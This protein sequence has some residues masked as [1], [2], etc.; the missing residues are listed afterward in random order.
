ML[1]TRPG[2][3]Y[4]VLMMEKRLEVGKPLI[5][6]SATEALIYESIF[7]S[8]LSCD[9]YISIRVVR[10]LRVD[11]WRRDVSLDIETI[12]TWLRPCRL[13]GLLIRGNVINFHWLLWEWYIYHNWALLMG[14]WYYGDIGY[15]IGDIM[16]LVVFAFFCMDIQHHRYC[17]I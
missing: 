11:V 5:W 17:K 7:T 2:M 9:K 12:P 10:R 13:H 4:N 6:C 14:L 1:Y 15:D 3:T 8:E 16:P